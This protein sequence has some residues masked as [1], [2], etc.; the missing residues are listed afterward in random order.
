MSSKKHVSPSLVAALAYAARGWHIYPSFSGTKAKTNLKWRTASTNNKKQVRHWW[1]KSPNATICLDCEKSGLAVL[2]LDQKDGKDGRLALEILQ[3]EYDKLPPTL[4]QRT[5]SGG[6]HLIF[7]G[8]IKTTVGANDQDGVIK[9]GLGEGIDTRGKGGM[10]VLAP[11]KLPNGQYEWL[12]DLAPEELPQWVADLAGTVPERNEAPDA[13]FTPTYSQEEFAERLNLIPVENYDCKHDA[14]L[15]LMLAST[16]ASTVEDGKEAFMEWTTRSGPGD[17]V[18]YVGDYDEIAARWN[19]NFA[20]RNMAGKAVKVG[21][22]NK[23][24]TDAG[25]GD[26]VKNP[27]DST[28]EEDFGVAQGSDGSAPLAAVSRPQVVL[29][30]GKLPRAARQTKKYLIGDSARSECS[31]SD[32]IFRR[33][34]KLAHLNR[35]ELAPEDDAHDKDYHVADDLVIRLADTDWLGDLAERCI[36]FMRFNKD[37]DLIPADVPDKLL[38]RVEKI[39]TPYDFPHLLGTVET[40]PVPL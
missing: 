3:L 38:R 31:A 22:F 2:D 14:W 15:E 29:E 11:T 4:M 7:K 21:T 33:G 12:N 36:R 35:N 25:H 24:L 30:K 8:Q 17:R 13:E 19:A 27:W 5:A 6:A 37:G 20:K 40:S 23:H 28:A 39:I 34:E 10:I 9:V 26:K 32:R 18:G 16:H 1:T